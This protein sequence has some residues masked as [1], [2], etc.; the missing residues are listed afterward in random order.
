MS[1][2]KKPHPTNRKNWGCGAR[3]INLLYTKGSQERFSAVEPYCIHAQI[4]GHQHMHRV[5]IAEASA[6]GLLRS[7]QVANILLNQIPAAMIT[8][9]RS[10]GVAHPP[11]T[12]DCARC[13]AARG[14]LLQAARGCHAP[15]EVDPAQTCVHAPTCR[16]KRN[17]GL[18]NS[19]MWATNANTAACCMDFC[20]HAYLLCYRLRRHRT[21]TMQHGGSPL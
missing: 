14:H 1:A 16:R 18:F 4:A 21:S 2:R 9:L 5:G 19:C 8:L 10:T 13:C 17:S 15:P 6:T 7:P 20:R 3:R 11:F 12:R